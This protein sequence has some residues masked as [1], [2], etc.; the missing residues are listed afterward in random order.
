MNRM[1]AEDPISF[2]RFHQEPHIDLPEIEMCLSLLSLLSFAFVS[3][4]CVLGQAQS[5]TL[6][7]IGLYS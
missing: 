4:P 5:G 2:S 6:R 7:P 1:L 3:F